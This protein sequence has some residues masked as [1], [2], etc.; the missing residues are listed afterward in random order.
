MRD[1]GRGIY[2][3]GNKKP[4]IAANEAGFLMISENDGL[5]TGIC[6]SDS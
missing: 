5:F 6:N 4:R 1:E 3:D 2:A